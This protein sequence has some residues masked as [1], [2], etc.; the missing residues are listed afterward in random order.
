MTTEV[1]ASRIELKNLARIALGLLR[2]VTFPQAAHVLA[3]AQG[4][5]RLL[6]ISAD[7]PP[8]ELRVDGMPSDAA[9]AAGKA[10]IADRAP[11]G[12]IQGSLGEAVVH[13]SAPRVRPRC[14]RRVGHGSLARRLTRSRRHRPWTRSGRFQP[15]DNRLSRPAG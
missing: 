10:S 12:R 4:S 2:A 7:L 13:R 1:A 3:L 6:A 8:D 11:S 14:G 5:V 15:L 9:S